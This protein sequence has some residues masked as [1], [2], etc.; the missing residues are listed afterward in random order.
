MSELENMVAELSLEEMDQVSGGYKKPPAKPGYEIYKIKK[1]DTL[2]RI[3]RHYQCT[4]AD[5]M[6]WNPKISDK[7][8][9]YYDDYIYILEK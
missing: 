9:I 8:K 5:I 4:V 7:N 1:G 3:A 2:G 6:R